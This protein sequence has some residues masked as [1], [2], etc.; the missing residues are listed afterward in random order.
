M[1]Q[2]CPIWEPGLLNPHSPA[3][4][5]FKIF[6]VVLQCVRVGGG[7]VVCSG[8]LMLKFAASFSEMH[9][10]YIIPIFLFRLELHSLVPPIETF[11]VRTCHATAVELNNP[12]FLRIS[13]IKRSSTQGF[14]PPPPT[15]NGYFV[16]QTPTWMFPWTLRFLISYR[17]HKN[18]QILFSHQNY[19][20]SIESLNKHIVLIY[21]RYK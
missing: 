7:G 4:T 15:K 8:R 13:I 17:L 9:H 12:H 11:T 1:F 18:Y 19:K 14:T 16:V 3:L 10:R 6:Y 21:S 20:Y 5:E 2:C